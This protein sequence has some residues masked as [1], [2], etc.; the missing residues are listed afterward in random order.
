MNP[1]TVPSKAM[2]APKA[3][4]APKHRARAANPGAAPP[5][6][7][8]IID[9]RSRSRSPIRNAPLTEGPISNRTTPSYHGTRLGSWHPPYQWWSVPMV[10]AYLGPEPPFHGV[11]VLTSRFFECDCYNAQRRCQSCHQRM[12][13]GCRFEGDTVFR[14]GAVVRVSNYCTICAYRVSTPWRWRRHL[15]FNQWYFGRQVQ[16]FYD[17]FVPSPSRPL[18]YN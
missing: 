14:P 2:P 12:C 16:R 18:N 3:A 11:H 10:R 17:E 15:S 5:R 9:I 7:A 8:V 1:I 4:A 6:P 13:D